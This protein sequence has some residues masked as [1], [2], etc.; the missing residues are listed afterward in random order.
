[1]IISIS[2]RKGSGKTLISN[3]FV[4][5][6][7]E[8]VSFAFFLKN[9]L[10][11]I[12]GISI[13][14]FNNEFDKERE[15]TEWLS[16]LSIEKLIREIEKYTNLDLNNYAINALNNQYKITN[17]R[18]LMQVVATEIIRNEDPDFHV[19]KT[20]SMLDNNKDYIIDDTRFENEFDIL[21][22]HKA[23]FYYISRPSNW[24]IS[25]HSSENNINPFKNKFKSMIHLLNI[26]D[27]KF[28]LEQLDRSKNLKYYIYN[29]LSFTE[30]WE[31]QELLF[32]NLG[33]FNNFNYIKYEIDSK[34]KSSLFFGTDVYKLKSNFES[35]QNA[36]SALKSSNYF[37]EKYFL[38]QI[39]NDSDKFPIIE[40]SAQANSYFCLTLFAELLK[41]TNLSTYP[42]AQTINWNSLAS[43]YEVISDIISSIYEVKNTKLIENLTYFYLLGLKS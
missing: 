29:S 1:M 26:K 22:K 8:K 11:S 7:F 31:Q 24:N 2:G 9:M 21:Q 18:T 3:F 12:T 10:S 14:E 19:K 6:G 40:I 23:Q 36:L 13:D 25:N 38:C 34:N 16:N 30:L 41:L 17:L 35:N 32:Y 27:E 15:R 4:N 33:L 39:F 20:L 5:K 42:Q 28:L 37:L 43:Q